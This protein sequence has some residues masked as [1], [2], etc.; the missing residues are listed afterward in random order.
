MH[1]VKHWLNQ[2]NIHGSVSIGWWSANR[3]DQLITRNW[4]TAD[5]WQ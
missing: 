5:P 3:T 4:L 2:F 1:S